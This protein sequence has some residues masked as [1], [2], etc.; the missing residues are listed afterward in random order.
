MY[1]ILYNTKFTWV[2]YFSEVSVIYSCYVIWLP[3]FIVNYPENCW[4]LHTIYSS[5]FLKGSFK[6]SQITTFRNFYITAQGLKHNTGVLTGIE[7]THQSTVRIHYT[8][9]VYWL[10]TSKLRDTMWIINK[11]VKLYG[12]TLHT[13]QNS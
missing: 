6:I 3:P 12:K 9:H 11:A 1:D 4:H 7:I 8:G 5:L 10:C 2:T 13:F